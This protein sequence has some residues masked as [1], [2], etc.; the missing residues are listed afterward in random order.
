MKIFDK[1]FQKNR[2]IPAYGPMFTKILARYPDN[3]VGKYVSTNGMYPKPRKCCTGLHLLT[4][5][6]LADS[7]AQYSLAKYVQYHL[8]NKEYPKYPIADN[9]PIDKPWARNLLFSFEN[10]MLT[11]DNFTA[12]QGLAAG[13]LTPTIDDT[14]TTCDDADPNSP[15]WCST[16]PPI[17]FSSFSPDTTN[18]YNANPAEDQTS[19]QDIATPS[20]ADLPADNTACFA[21]NLDT[22]A[23]PFAARDAYISNIATF[24]SHAKGYIMNDQQPSSNMSFS[25]GAS[26][27]SMYL[28]AAYQQGDPACAASGQG[29]P[30][31]SGTSIDETVCHTQLQSAV[32]NC[33]TGSTSQKFGGYT[34]SKCIV[35]IAG[36][37]GTY[38]VDG[39]LPPAP[40]PS[41]EG[42][43]RAPPTPTPRRL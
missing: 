30:L 37:S 36:V 13:P 4:H 1:D 28:G 40:T 8:P 9:H 32:D 7:Y 19:W 29:D 35:W 33:D 20:D 27:W 34:I 14:G 23:Q 26:D 22:S 25:V 41:G 21:S 17:G 6:L 38:S 18:F 24:C 2:T 5:R 42:T 43:P 31:L 3:N 16:D 15:E 39:A 10:G 12:L 11:V